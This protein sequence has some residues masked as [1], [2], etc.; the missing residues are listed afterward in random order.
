MCDWEPRD[1]YQQGGWFLCDAA[2]D[3][4]EREGL[5]RQEA[6]EAIH[7]EERDDSSKD[8]WRDDD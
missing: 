7:P 6:V 3:L 2:L 5:S 4:M 1:R 8:E